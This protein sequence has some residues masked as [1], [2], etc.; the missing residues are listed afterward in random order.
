MT[1]RFEVKSPSGVFSSGDRIGIL[2]RQSYDFDTF[3]REGMTPIMAA[4]DGVDGS[5]KT[6]RFVDDGTHDGIWEEVSAFD[7]EA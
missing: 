7:G 3:M 6:W 2:I 4:Y 1:A 5:M